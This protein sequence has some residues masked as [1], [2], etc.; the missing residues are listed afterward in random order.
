MTKITI[1]KEFS[2]KDD[3]V[4]VPREEYEALLEL[5]KV[6]E[7]TPTAADKKALARGRKNFKEG[8]YISA[9]EL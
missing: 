5:R 8:N 7:F 1:P 3:F 4:A 6:K 2:E 9:D